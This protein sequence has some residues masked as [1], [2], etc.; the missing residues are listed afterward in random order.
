MIAMRTPTQQA[1]AEAHIEELRPQYEGFLLQLAEEAI[2]GREGRPWRLHDSPESKRRI[3]RRLDTI[4]SAY[5]AW[6]SARRSIQYRGPE[7][8]DYLQATVDCFV[9]QNSSDKWIGVFRHFGRRQVDDAHVLV[10]LKPYVEKE[11]DKRVFLAVASSWRKSFCLHS[12]S[13]RAVIR[14]PAHTT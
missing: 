3:A 10:L 12:Y 13:A 6:E 14:N 2:P 9:E 11:S 8:E 1:D 7:D 5:C 4:V